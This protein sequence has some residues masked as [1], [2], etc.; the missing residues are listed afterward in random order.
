VSPMRAAFMRFPLIAALTVGLGSHVQPA[1]SA[2]PTIATVRFLED[3]DRTPRPAPQVKDFRVELSFIGGAIFG[4][5][6][7]KEILEPSIDDDYRF[8]LDVDALAEEAE[9]ASTRVSDQIGDLVIEPAATSLARVA[10]FTMDSS[11]K[12]PVG[13][14]AWLD[15]ET[16]EILL[17][18]HFDRA[19]TIKGRL[20]E[21]E[22]EYRFD[23]AI[24]QPGFSWLRYKRAD[25]KVTNIVLTT[26]P[27][28]VALSVARLPQARK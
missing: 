8:A 23:V 6:T 22:R 24:P 15:G 3:D 9:R 5:P 12:K 7:T 26:W 27:S 11:M 20:S 2:E 21:Q 16:N 17:L 10:T 1:D 19:C 25:E 28:T 14:T 4:R 18:I 13:S